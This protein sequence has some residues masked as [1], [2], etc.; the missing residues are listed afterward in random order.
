MTGRKYHFYAIVFL[1]IINLLGQIESK[2]ITND[3]HIVQTVYKL[4]NCSNRVRVWDI[5]PEVTKGRYDRV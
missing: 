4:H 2:D 1:K 3:S 5:A